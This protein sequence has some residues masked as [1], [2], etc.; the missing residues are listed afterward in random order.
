M[1]RYNKFVSAIVSSGV[2]MLF[3]VGVYYGFAVESAG[4]ADPDV[5][6]CVVTLFGMGA[7]KMAVFLTSVITWAGVFAGPA[8]D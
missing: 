8:N 2:G 3:A 5:G 6:E 7:D 4:C 1:S